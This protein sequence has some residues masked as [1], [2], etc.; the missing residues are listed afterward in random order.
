MCYLFFQTQINFTLSLTYSKVSLILKYF[1]TL[2]MVGNC[3][4]RL[5]DLS[6][7]LT[8]RPWLLKDNFNRVSALTTLG[9]VLTLTI[10]FRLDPIFFLVSSVCILPK[11]W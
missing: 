9:L 5:F 2:V 11:K 1:A 10:D 8:L 4:I 7:T 3:L 6:N